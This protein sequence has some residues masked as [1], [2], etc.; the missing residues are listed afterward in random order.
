MSTLPRSRPPSRPRRGAQHQATDPPRAAVANPIPATVVTGDV[1][2]GAV[3]PPV[4]LDQ[5]AEQSRKVLN[6]AAE[7]ARE[8]GVRVETHAIVGGA[9]E[10]LVELADRLHVDVIVVGSRGML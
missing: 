5:L 9:A 2:I 10:V 8:A 1:L 3:A 7:P 4:Q 6:R